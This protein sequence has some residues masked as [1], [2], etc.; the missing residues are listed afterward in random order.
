MT[1]MSDPQHTGADEEVVTQQENINQDTATDDSELAVEVDLLKA[2]NR[3]L[4]ELLAA[5][6]R[7]RYRNTAIALGSVGLLCGI[8]GVIVPTGTDVLFALAGIGVFGG[9]LTYFLTPERFISADVGKQV[10]TATADS[11]ERLCHDLGLSDRRLYVAASGTENVPTGPSNQ[12]Q[13]ADSWLFIPQTA[14]TE[15]PDFSTLNSSF[16][17]DD[18]QRGLSIRP[19]GSGLLATVTR[20]LSEPL[21]ETPDVICEQLADAIVEDLEL[22]QSM[23]YEIDPATSRISVQI[24][25]VLYGDGTQFDHPVVSLIAVGLAAGLEHPVEPTVTGTDPLSVTLRTKISDG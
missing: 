24:T 4:R 17:I 22:A 20:S 12:S 7:S 8:L 19:T 1:S 6:Q 18:G 3:R 10:Y 15:V 11:F 25:G 14:E 2:E 5:A 21:G 16:V 23:T 9:V 13:L